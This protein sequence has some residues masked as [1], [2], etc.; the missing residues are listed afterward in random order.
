MYCK[1]TLCLCR[2]WFQFIV[3]AEPK[4]AQISQRRRVLNVSKICFIDG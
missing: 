3:W 1:C 4:S 2:L